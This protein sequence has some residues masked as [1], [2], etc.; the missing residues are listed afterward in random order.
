MGQ[1]ER[2]PSDEVTCIDP[3]RR[4]DTNWHEG[5]RVELADGRKG[6]YITTAKNWGEDSFDYIIRI[7]GR[8]KCTK[9]V[10]RPRLSLEKRV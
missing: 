2:W 8:T 3:N 5:D 7:D 4:G 1:L 9:S 10:D 6:W